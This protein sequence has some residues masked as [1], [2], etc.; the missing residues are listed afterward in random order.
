MVGLKNF[1]EDNYKY[2]EKI[3]RKLNLLINNH[4]SVDDLVYMAMTAF[5]ER[6]FGSAKDFKQEYKKWMN[7]EPHSE[8][9]SVV[10]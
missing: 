2:K 6:G 9:L 5:I 8:K 10:G 4:P 7:D 1:G 3:I